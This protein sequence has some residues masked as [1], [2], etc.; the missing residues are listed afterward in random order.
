MYRIRME[1]EYHT[2]VDVIKD[3]FYYYRDYKMLF[4]I[5]VEF[6]AA[7]THLIDKILASMKTWRVI[8]KYHLPLRGF[9]AYVLQSVYITGIRSSL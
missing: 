9:S 6:S 2:V 8:C 4:A 1:K 7:I 5:V 3:F